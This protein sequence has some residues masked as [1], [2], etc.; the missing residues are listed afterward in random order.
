LSEGALLVAYFGHGSITQWGK[1]R[2][3]TTDDVATLT[4][5]HRLPVVLNMT[6]L[7]GLFTHPQVDSLAE[8]LLWQQ[9]G[10]AVAVLAPTSLTLPGDQSFLS[11]ALAEALFR[12]RLPTLGQALLQAQ[13]QIPTD[14]PGTRDVMRTF[15]L[16]GDPALRVAYPQRR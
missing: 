6:C 15:L 11:R 5:G 3:F 9:E 10:G 1:D 4:N 7:T 2:I 13:R 12:D 16:F 14:E 8:T